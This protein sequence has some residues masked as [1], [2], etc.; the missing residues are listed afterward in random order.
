MKPDQAALLTGIEKQQFDAMPILTDQERDWF[1]T[2]NDAEQAACAKFHNNFTQANF[3]LF[4]GYF[5]LKKMRLVLTWSQT[6]NDLKYIYSR[7][8]PAAKHY[9][10]N[11]DKM[12][13][14]RIYRSIFQLSDYSLCTPAWRK[15][16][17][18][19]LQ[20]AAHQI[21]N[22]RFLMDECLQFLEQHLVEVPVYST[23]DK[24][25]AH[26]V[27]QADSTLVAR[28]KNL[29]TP[30]ELISLQALLKQTEDAHYGITHLKKAIK[31]FSPAQ[32]DLAIEQ[33]R[34]LSALYPLAKRVLNSSGLSHS[35]IKQMALIPELYSASQ[36]KQFKPFKAGL[37]LLCYVFYQHRKINDHLVQAYVKLI[38]RFQDE[39]HTY[40]LQHRQDDT[41]VVAK[42]I[43]NM[44]GVLNLF[45]DPTVHEATPFSRIR[46]MAFQFVPEK[47][48]PIIVRYFGGVELD[49]KAYAWDYCDNQMS[50]IVRNLR[51]LFLAID[52]EVSADLPVLKSQVARAQKTLATAPTRFALDKRFVDKE[53][54][55]YLFVADP[56]HQT[57]QAHR[58][59]WY[60]YQKIQKHLEP[61][62][63]FVSDS[64]Q[65]R[66][67][68]DYFV[69]HSALTEDSYSRLRVP[70]STQ[71]AADHLDQLRHLLDD[72][73]V[74]TAERI[75]AQ[76]NDFIKVVGAGKQIKWGRAFA[77]KNTLND[78]MFADAPHPEPIIQLLRWANRETGFCGL[79]QHA[80][81]Q[82]QHSSFSV[83]NVL[84]CLIA[85]G[86]NVGLFN[87]SKTSDRT[88]HL[89]L[90]T[91][92]SYVTRES[93]RAANDCL[94]NMTAGLPIYAYYKN[95]Q[96]TLHASADGQKFETQ[97]RSAM[98][99]Y[100]PKYFGMQPGISVMTL[101][102]G[103]LPLRSKVIS[104]ND[105]ES[106]HLYD[107]LFN[108]STEVTF[109]VVSTDQHG[110]N[111]FNFAVL[112]AFGY[113]FAP[114]YAKFK[115]R[116]QTHFKLDP[117]A[118]G[119]QFL[120]MKK[121]IDWQLILEEWDNLI[122]IMVSL[123]QR[124]AT[125]ALLVKKLCGY[126][127]YNKT[128][129]A[130][131]EYN[132]VLQ[133][134]YLL[135]YADDESLRQHTQGA[136]NIGE[137]FHQMNR[138]IATANGR[139]AIKGRSEIDFDVWNESAKLIVNCILFYNTYIL[140][141]LLEHYR[142]ANDPEGIRRVIGTSP[143]AW[144]HI[145]MSGYFLFASN[146]E[147]YQIEQVIDA[148]K[149]AA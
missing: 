68:S 5:K 35:N 11:V 129:K 51:P 29:V 4:L 143:V 30:D 125:Q 6:Q 121:S 113:Q 66:A 10:R 120:V 38:R 93:L 126:Q 117:G 146:N 108:Q 73:L 78:S 92:L 105:H 139:N 36:L 98:A 52:F 86:T 99:R 57:R 128:L 45:V 8:F 109:D 85:N 82:T 137:S 67:L 107:L 100:S 39:A 48:I 27:Q 134:I 116:F 115:H 136:L 127:K 53:E 87:L 1:F 124:N 33:S 111:A 14:S 40:M 80:R 130:L 96:G 147:Q 56:A 63:L 122:Q 102:A 58:C 65:Y 17:E 46:Q 90:Q 119:D 44:A 135:D 94:V 16:L 12:M 72:K 145:N 118:T 101:V 75:R 26:A 81:A 22:K 76:Q 62:E 131:S 7:Y 70:H 64:L 37:Y 103:H 71:A 31:D 15:K 77:A 21:M 19:H 23:L 148:L 112:Y 140:S 60:F 84:A 123:D 95:Q 83:D 24:L 142:A 61:G 47:E 133:L 138:A 18:L 144:A 42:R 132:R 91:Q 114:R 55:A 88:H 50:T 41:A 89:L 69:P 2:L 34:L 79:F 43:G 59:E 32:T 97:W 74:T 3:I 20:D 54:S 9:R 28:I 49:K 106:H 13:R 149:W 25:I 141:K 110:G 104:A